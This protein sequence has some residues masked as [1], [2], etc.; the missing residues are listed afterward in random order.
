MGRWRHKASKTSCGCKTFYFVRKSPWG[1]PELPGVF[2]IEQAQK[3][4]GG[5]KLAPWRC[6]LF[7]FLEMQGPPSHNGRGRWQKQGAFW[8]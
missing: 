4:I 1:I 3:I 7:I 2:C 8:V 5:S 6:G